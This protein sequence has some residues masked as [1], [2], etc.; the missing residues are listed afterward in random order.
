MVRRLKGSRD[1]F[2]SRTGDANFI[3]KAVYRLCRSPYFRLINITSAIFIVD[4]YVILVEGLFV[5]YC[6]LLFS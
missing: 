3:R 4:L 1:S 2:R 6:R 5:I